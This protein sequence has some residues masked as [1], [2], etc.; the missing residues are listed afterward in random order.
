MKSKDMKRNIFYLLFV[1]LLSAC[2]QEEFSPQ[3]ETLGYLSIDNISVEVK[4][5]NYV[6][7]KAVDADFYVKI[8]GNGQTHI[9]APGEVPREIALDAG[10]YTVSV[11]NYETY[12]EGKPLY[13]TET[14]VTI[15]AGEINYISIQVPLQNVG[16]R[17]V[18]PDNFE[19]YFTYTFSV[20]QGEQTQSLE[21]GETYYFESAEFDSIFYA[22]NVTNKDNEMRPADMGSIDVENGNI[23]VITYD[24]ATESLSLLAN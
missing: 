8:D 17:L 16:I 4:N 7:T 1:I 23:Y 18:L 21:D 12:Q 19:D 3:E 13:S 6:S 22:M 15:T 2:Q 11:Y 5:M 24:Y 20:T 9:Y 10:N 14:S